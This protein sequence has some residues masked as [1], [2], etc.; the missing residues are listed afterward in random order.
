M[1]KNGILIK[2]HFAE[3]FDMKACR[4][5]ITADSLSW[6]QAAATSMTG[7]AT[8]VIACGCEAGIEAELSQEETLDG[9]VGI[10]VLL[11]AMDWDGLKKHVVRRSGQCVMTAP[12]SAL[13]S[14][15]AADSRD[16]DGMKIPLGSTLRYFGDGWQR[17]K[18][19]GGRR[20]W[21]IPVMEGEFLC[22]DHSWGMAAIGGGN[23]LIEAIDRAS[24]L[25]AA[26]K[27]V[28]A[29]AGAGIIMPFPGGIVR[30]GS[31]VG[32]KY[33]DLIASTNQAHCPILRGVVATAFA[34]DVGSVLEIV[35][36]GI[37]FESISQAMRRGIEAVCALGKR[38]GVVAI[39]AGNY[40]GK[41]GKHHFHLRKIMA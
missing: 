38:G 14:G 41:L 31:K 36:N 33:K 8:S 16:G 32:S 28:Q 3:A 7:F 11:F 17:S 37:D 40:G 34:E 2:D 25:R 22:S 15:S 9:R 18:L 19:L 24:A 30:S 13:F 10:S 35:I 5:V 20:Y 23:F 21:R 12:S 26:E 29:A 4:L 6:A 27:A 1:I 39:D